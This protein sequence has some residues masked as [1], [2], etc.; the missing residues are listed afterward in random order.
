MRMRQDAGETGANRYASRNRIRPIHLSSSRTS[1]DGRFSPSGTP[2]SR[3]VSAGP[4]PLTAIVARPFANLLQLHLSGAGRESLAR[5][6][7]NSGCAPSHAMSDAIPL[8]SPGRGQA[9]CARASVSSM[10]QVPDG[11]AGSTDRAC[12]Q[13]GSELGLPR[14]VRPRETLQRAPAVRSGGGGPRLQRHGRRKMDLGERGTNRQSSP[15]ACRR[16]IQARARL[17]EGSGPTP[18]KS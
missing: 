8:R 13:T 7:S 18:M 4:I 10:P 17:P 9:M 12:S 14:R 1:K 6:S 2:A 5:T 3:T 11:R 16:Q 15:P